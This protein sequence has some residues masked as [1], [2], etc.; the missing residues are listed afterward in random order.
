MKHVVAVVIL[1]W[2]DYCNSMLADL[3]WQNNCTTTAS[4]ECCGLTFPGLVALALMELHWLPVYCHIQFILAIPLHMVST[5]APSYIKGTSCDLSCHWLCSANTIKY[6]VP[7]MG[8]EHSLTGPSA[9]NFAVLETTDQG[10][11]WDFV[12]RDETESFRNFLETETRR[13]ILSS[14]WDRDE[15]FF[16][17][18]HFQNWLRFD[19]V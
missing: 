14:R 12:V 9:R 3:L 1:S 8:R 18:V 5:R 11:K 15:T 10:C 19:E 13:L 7:V 2:L 17:T 6:V 4:L 16:N